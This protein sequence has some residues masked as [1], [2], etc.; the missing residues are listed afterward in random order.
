LIWAATR[1][2]TGRG[3]HVHRVAKYVSTP[4]FFLSK[5]SCFND[6]QN[7]L[8]LVIGP[9]LFKIRIKLFFCGRF[10]SQIGEFGR[11]RPE[12]KTDGPSNKYRI[13]TY[14]TPYYKYYMLFYTYKTPYYKYYMLFYTYYTPCRI[15]LIR[16]YTNLFVHLIRFGTTLRIQ[17]LIQTL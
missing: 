5:G 1:Q 11:K 17:I 16:I 6:R 15:Y 9:V 10:W 7:V 4:V 12:K 2:I 8:L 3:S 13:N 14:K